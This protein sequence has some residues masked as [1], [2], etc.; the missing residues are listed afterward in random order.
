MFCF[1][2]VSNKYLM[3]LVALALARTCFISPLPT[4]DRFESWGVGKKNT[5]IPLL[6]SA[7]NYTAAFFL[8]AAKTQLI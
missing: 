4:L 2:Q 5:Q 6:P 8:G 3:Q 7:T 1:Y